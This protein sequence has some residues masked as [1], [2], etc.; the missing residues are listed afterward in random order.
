[1]RV[2]IYCRVSLEEMN[3]DN[4]ELSLVEYCKRMN[5]DYTIYREKESTRKT[6][7]IKQELLNKLRHK[8]YDA[9]LVWKLD[10]WARS[11]I[12]LLTEIKELYDKNVM[13]ISYTDNIDLSTPSGKLQFTILSAF[14]E[15]ER[16]L[17]RLRTI[18]GMKRAKSQGKHCGRPRKF[19]K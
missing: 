14:C 2:A 5:Y 3:L 16:D 15:F 19:N 17:I 11:S 10:R 18:E 6:R 9:V 13:F 12:E 1:M 4:Q 8:E 7:P